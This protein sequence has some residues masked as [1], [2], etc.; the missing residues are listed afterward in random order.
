[1]S[2]LVFLLS[3]GILVAIWYLHNYVADMKLILMDYERELADL[4]NYFKQ[5]TEVPKNDPPIPKYKLTVEILDPIGLA[6]RESSMAKVAGDIAPHIVNKEVYAQ[7]KEE[8]IKELQR[9]NVEAK[10]DII[11]V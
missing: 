4:K 3:I 11:I 2:I 7:A 10:V 8:T 9:R 5:G 1:M 6:K